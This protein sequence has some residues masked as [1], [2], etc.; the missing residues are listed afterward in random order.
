M[1]MQNPMF[2]F[3]STRIYHDWKNNGNFR[4]SRLQRLPTGNPLEKQGSRCLVGES[5]ITGRFSSKPRLIA[6]T[7][8]VP[9]RARSPSLPWPQSTRGPDTGLWR[10][11]D[12]H[13]FVSQLPSVKRGNGNHIINKGWI[14]QQ[15]M[16]VYWRVWENTWI[17]CLK[18]WL[19]K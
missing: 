1:A 16:F 6:D 15:A 3:V 7:W 12:P 17:S 4:L 8:N 2:A 11:G 18:T 9:W 10:F 5:T 14:F 19:A 13:G